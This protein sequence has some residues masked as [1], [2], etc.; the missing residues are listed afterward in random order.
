MKITFNEAKFLLAILICFQFGRSSAQEN[1]NSTAKKDSCQTTEA[2]RSFKVSQTQSTRQAEK[3]TFYLSTNFRFGSLNRTFDQLFGMDNITAQ[4]GVNYGFTKF[5]QMGLSRESLGK[6][7]TLSSKFKLYQKN[8]KFPLNLSVYGSFNFRG[9]K[10]VSQETP[11]FSANG[12][13][14]Q[15]IISTKLFNRLSLQFSPSL[16]KMKD[17][18]L[19]VFE[20]ETSYAFS[21]SSAYWINKRASIF[22][23]YS[24]NLNRHQ[25]SP[26]TD[27][28]SLGAEIE[29][30]KNLFRF[31]ISNSS[32][33]DDISSILTG[34]EDKLYIGV[35]Y[36]REF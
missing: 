2:F 17:I 10:H 18:G 4:F 36:L 25:N 16:M 24:T 1:R 34:E 27:V 21:I 14:F 31:L 12:I 30:Q 6:M 11:Y 3:G 13:F 5:F 32:F 22:L 33:N 9:V 19:L 26:Y 28:L 29:F 15:P 35:N 23:D 8:G 20:N 7:I